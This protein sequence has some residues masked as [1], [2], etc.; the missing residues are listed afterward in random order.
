MGVP[1]GFYWGYLAFSSARIQLNSVIETYIQ[2]SAVKSSMKDSYTVH[3]ACVSISLS[4]GSRI[5]A[6]CFRPST[7]KRLLTNLSFIVIFFNSCLSFIHSFP[8]FGKDSN[9]TLVLHNSLPP[10]IGT[11]LSGMNSWAGIPE[12]LNG[13]TLQRSSHSRFIG[14]NSNLTISLKSVHS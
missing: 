13:F 8:L 1:P 11:P 4:S 6:K 9:Y 2:R 5:D 10:S 3:C 7:N 12:P 14:S